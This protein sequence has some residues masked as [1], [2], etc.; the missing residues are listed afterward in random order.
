VELPADWRSG[1]QPGM[2][3]GA[4]GYFHAGDLPEMGFYTRAFQ[5]C[6]RLVQTLGEPAAPLLLPFFN[7]IDSC[8]VV[9]IP[10][11]SPLWARVVIK[12]PGMPP[13][14]RYFYFETDAAHM[15]EITGSF[16]L[17]LPTSPE[18][19]Y[20]FPSGPL[21]PA[22]QLFWNTPRQ[23]A[24][25]MPLIETRLAVPAGD[26]PAKNDQFVRYVPQELW[27]WRSFPNPALKTDPLV[28]ANKV[29]ARFGFELRQAQTQEAGLYELYQDGNR[30]RERVTSWKAPILSSSG[31]NFALSLNSPN[32]HELLR[33]GGLE[34]WEKMGPTGE[35][36]FLGEELLAPYWNSG[37]SSIDLR[38]ENQL[39]YR[40]VTLFGADF[41]LEG[42]QVWQN[43][44]LLEVRGFLIQ[45]GAI[46]N[47]ALG[48]EEIFGWRLLNGRPFYFFRKGPRVGISYDGQVQPVYYDDVAHY[49]CCGL[50]VNNPHSTAAMLQFY[51]LREGVWYSVQMG[52]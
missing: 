25:G 6:M 20:A 11:N 4:N 2:L 1:D 41:G 23:P 49:L 10:Y 16:K 32:G 39:I 30:I 14:K 33:R 8:Q 31:R 48:Y 38:K 24:A 15:T 44:W 29:L 27:I 50:A 18:D 36:H 34:Q 9:P 12:A 47:N 3:K 46:L 40:F 7:K 42:F 35:F 13:E 37:Y 19:F 26:S 5:V 51:A 45:D 52:N 17:L 28:E 21:R 22:D 43:H